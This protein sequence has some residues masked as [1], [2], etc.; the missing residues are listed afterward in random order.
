MKRYRGAELQRECD[1]VLAK[2][3]ATPPGRCMIC[4]STEEVKEVD[5]I[6]A[7]RLTEKETG[8]LTVQA[9]VKLRLCQKHW[10][11]LFQQHEAGGVPI[12]I[13]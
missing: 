8:V 10:T 6:I 5:T 7:D 3:A 9:H 2:C 12:E 13:R 11:A 4:W 1:R